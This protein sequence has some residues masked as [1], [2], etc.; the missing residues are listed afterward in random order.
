MDDLNNFNPDFDF[1]KLDALALNKEKILF[2]EISSVFNNSY[3]IWADIAGFPLNTY[4]Y[5]L[6][7]FSSKSRFLL[8]ALNYDSENNRILFHQVIIANE[9]QIREKYCKKC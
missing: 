9:N 3:S 6:I 4:H 8:I 5:F 7:G 1:T 2:S